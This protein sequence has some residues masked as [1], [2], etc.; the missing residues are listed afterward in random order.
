MGFAGEG[1][2]FVIAISGQ[3]NSLPNG[4]QALAVDRFPA[5][6]NNAGVIN[7]TDG[8]ISLKS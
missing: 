8:L 6:M 1:A 7:H 5:T 3:A 2:V 4:N